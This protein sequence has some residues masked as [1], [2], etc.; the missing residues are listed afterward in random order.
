MIMPVRNGKI[1]VTKSCVR[2]VIIL[3]SWPIGEEQAT[4]TLLA[5]EARQ[6]AAE[7]MKLAGEVDP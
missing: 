6:V 1:Q 4:L 2:G 7:L 3:K 5:D